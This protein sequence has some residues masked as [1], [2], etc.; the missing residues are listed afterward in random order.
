M[1]MLMT[2]MMM[3]L[4]QVTS[5]HDVTNPLESTW[6]LTL[7]TPERM[8][9]MPRKYHS[10]DSCILHGVETMIHRETQR[11]FLLG[12]VCE[13]ENDDESSS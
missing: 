10:Y 3:M 1:K 2:M 5:A 6:E 7:V 9:D 11:E 13:E 12:F 4:V 8:I